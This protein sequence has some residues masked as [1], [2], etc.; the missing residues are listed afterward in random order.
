MAIPDEAFTL[1]VE[2][3]Y[4]IVHPDTRELQS[5][6]QAILPKAKQAVGD[7]VTPEM[8]RSQIEIGTPICRTLSEVHDELRRLRSE[9]IAAAEQTGNRIV[10]AGTHPFSHWE[11]QKLTRRERYRELASDFQQLTREQLIFG[12]HVHVGIPNREL[13]IQVMNRARPW[14]AALLALAGNSPFWL[15]TNTGYA[16]FRTEIWGRWPTA[17]VPQVFNAWADYEQLVNELVSTKIIDD[18]SKIYWD[19][20]PSAHY[21]TLEFR[22]TDVCLTVDEAVLIAGLVRAIAR[23]C[24]WD[25]EGY[26]PIRHVRDELL[27][28]AKWQAARFGLN[29]TLIDPLTAQPTP[30]R[31]LINKLLTYVQPALETYGDKER[32]TNLVKQVFK[33]GNGAARQRAVYERTGSLENVVDFMIEETAR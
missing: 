14:L 6:A 5:S 20:R 22:V 11:D 2:E 18:A 31:Q 32:I 28:A 33:N 7:Q 1:G 29:Q 15:G 25:A 10:A 27:Q 13:A 26:V 8:Y 30:A 21:N 23:T 17:G 9:V 19:V 16:S 12:C 3:E 4:Q 24:A